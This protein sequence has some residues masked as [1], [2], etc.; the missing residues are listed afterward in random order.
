[1]VRR[2]DRSY[3]QLPLEL[4]A[5]SR[6]ERSEQPGRAI[7]VSK[8]GLRVQTRCSLIPGEEVDVFLRGVP[9]PYAFCRVVWAHMWQGNQIAEAGLQILEDSPPVQDPVNDFA[10]ELRH[11]Y[12]NPAGS[13]KGSHITEI[14]ISAHSA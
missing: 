2:Y 12:H 11:A 4:I 13:A 3:S 10:D 8:G 1:M 9:K 14:D 5:T 7:D 6:K